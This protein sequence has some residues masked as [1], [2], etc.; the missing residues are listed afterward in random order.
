[1]VTWWPIYRT[2]DVCRF[3]I[4]NDDRRAGFG[5]CGAVAH[6]WFLLWSVELHSMTAKH[7]PGPPMTLGNMREL[8]V[9]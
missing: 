3:R 4:A 6:V 1:M 9:L 2:I 8:G 5:V 7:P